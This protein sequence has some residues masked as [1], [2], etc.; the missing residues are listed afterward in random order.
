MKPPLAFVMYNAHSMGDAMGDRLYSLIEHRSGRGG[1]HRTPIGVVVRDADEFLFRL[2]EA[3]VVPEGD[4][5]RVAMAARALASRLRR[6]N[7]RTLRELE[8]FAAKE[9]NEVRL[10]PPQRFTAGV[11]AAEA[12]DLLFNEHVRPVEAVL[13]SAAPY[14]QSTVASLDI[15]ESASMRE[16]PG[17]E[18]GGYSI[19]F[20]GGATTTL[21]FQIRMHVVGTMNLETSPEVT[22]DAAA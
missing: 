19:A 4:A 21:S 8:L 17:F 5:A 11:G 22:L 10:G 2:L 15:C 16:L 13:A 18:I 12:V 9:A 1:A 20:A 6:E 7:P 3:P 14:S